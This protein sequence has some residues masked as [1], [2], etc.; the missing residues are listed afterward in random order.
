MREEFEI[1]EVKSVEN[2]TIAMGFDNLDII[3]NKKNG[4][5]F[6]YAKQIA[7]GLGLSNPTSMISSADIDDEDKDYLMKQTAKGPR[8]AAI[9]S[10]DG[11]I[12]CVMNSR[13]KKVKPFKKWIVKDVIRQILEV[14]YYDSLLDN[15]KTEFGKSMT[16]AITNKNLKLDK[17]E[18]LKNEGMKKIRSGKISEER[19]IEIINN[20]R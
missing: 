15:H 9:I 14:G 5:Y 19:R 18:E 8:K 11:V 7:D 4:K 16:R 6:F 10:I 20:F 12:E 3:K 17:K 13:N 2:F 1:K